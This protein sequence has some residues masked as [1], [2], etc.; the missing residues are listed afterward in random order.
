MVAVDFLIGKNSVKKYLDVILSISNT[1]F[2]SK[3][4]IE[5]ITT[6]RL[7]PSYTLLQ[8]RYNTTKSK[9]ANMLSKSI[10]APVSSFTSP[11]NHHQ[12]HHH[13]HRIHHPKEQVNTKLTTTSPHTGNPRRSRNPLSLNHSTI[14]NLN[15][16]P[17]YNT[18]TTTDPTP[19]L[20]SPHRNRQSSRLRPRRAL[21]ERNTRDASVWILAHNDPDPRTSG[22]GSKKIHCF[23]RTGG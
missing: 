16:I 19:L 22:R 1:H 20:R 15:P 18:P 13:V 7:S 11:H 9:P 12:P 2:N 5:S 23:Q 6:T 8:T 4:S 3:S 21:H 10:R 17:P 14:L